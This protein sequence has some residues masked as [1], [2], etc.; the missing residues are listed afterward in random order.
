[1]LGAGRTQTE[2]A[3]TI[4][5]SRKTVNQWAKMGPD[6]LQRFGRA[7]RPSKLTL[8]QWVKVENAL[9]AGPES[10][11]LKAKYWS[12]KSAQDYV[13]DVV[14]IPIGRTTIWDTLNQLGLTRTATKCA[15]RKA[16]NER[17]K[18]RRKEQGG[19]WQ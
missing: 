17:R 14:K 2:V 12:V 13:R 1:L 9:V 7:G 10:A 18:E 3:K 4:G 15:A 19:Y 6:E 11:G 5:V 16:A 8:A